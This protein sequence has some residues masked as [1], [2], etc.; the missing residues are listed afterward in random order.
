MKIFAFATFV[1]AAL[2]GTTAVTDVMLRGTVSGVY[3]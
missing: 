3:M 1:L 2:V